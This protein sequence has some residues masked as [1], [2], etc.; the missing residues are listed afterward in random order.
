MQCKEAVTDVK[1]HFL[2]PPLLLWRVQLNQSIDKAFLLVWAGSP[3]QGRLLNSKL[4]IASNSA[5]LYFTCHIC[6]LDQVR[7]A[8]SMEYPYQACHSFWPSLQKK[9]KLLAVLHSIKIII[10]LGGT[11]TPILVLAFVMA[12]I[13]SRH[14]TAFVHERWHPEYVEDSLLNQGISSSR[15]TQGEQQQQGSHISSDCNKHQLWASSRN[16]GFQRFNRLPSPVL[17]HHFKPG[18]SL[19]KIINRAV[20]ATHQFIASKDL[21]EFWI[22]VNYSSVMCSFGMCVEMSMYVFCCPVCSHSHRAQV[23]KLRSNA[24]GEERRVPCTCVILDSCSTKILLGVTV[25]CQ[26]RRTQASLL[27]RWED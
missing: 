27:R 22:F 20:T 14:P 4:P 11:A 5:G 8:P 23:E 16:R 13:I 19:L 10:S 12:G 3:P 2:P 15:R 9:F 7:K 18:N 25:S 21:L 17:L 6:T 1:S 24:A 26:T